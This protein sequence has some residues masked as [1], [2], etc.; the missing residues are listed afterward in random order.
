MR[1]L[2]LLLAITV[3]IWSGLAIATYNAPVHSDISDLQIR[4]KY[5]LCE[6][7]DMALLARLNAFGTGVAQDPE[8]IRSLLLQAPASPELWCDLA[9]ALRE[10]NKLAEVNQ[11][12]ANAVKLAPNSP[13]I[14]LRAATSKLIDNRGSEALPLFR[15]LFDK[16]PDYPGDNVFSLCSRFGITSAT[17]L[18]AV[19]PPDQPKVAAAYLRFLMRSGPTANA[20]GAWTWIA[21][22]GLATE[23]LSSEYAAYLLAKKLP[24]PAFDAWTSKRKYAESN[25]IFN[26]GFEDSGAPG[27]PFG[28]RM[29]PIPGVV[30][31]AIDPNERHSGSSSLRIRFNGQQNIA[32]SH[33]SQQ[34]VVTPGTYTLSAWIKTDMITTDE[35]I[36]IGIEDVQK[37]ASFQWISD[38]AFTGSR[39][40][41]LVSQQLTIPVGSPLVRVLILRNSSGKIDSK[42]NGNVWLDDVELRPRNP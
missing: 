18:A 30:G 24:G 38:P 13:H 41:T 21:A 28:W 2:T 12:Y 34:T 40:W 14:L 4:C 8:L 27:G 7:R 22:H 6:D 17:I 1:I 5:G 23:S 39:P 29:D 19:I 20:T 37:P 32:F 9:E 15:H 42:I 31:V 11:A 16:A 10:Q 33:V 26:P 25:R 3:A 36:R 35:G